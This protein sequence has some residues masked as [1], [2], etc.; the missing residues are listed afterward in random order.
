MYLQYSKYVQYVLS[1]SKKKPSHFHLELSMS[2]I[3][4]SKAI[5]LGYYALMLLLLL[6]QDI[7][8][9][10]QQVMCLLKH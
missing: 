6:L 7:H 8:A 1:T 10:K 3:C 4:K 5:R 9:W 2:Y